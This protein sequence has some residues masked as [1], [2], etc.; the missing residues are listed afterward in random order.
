MTDEEIAEMMHLTI[1]ELLNLCHNRATAMIVLSL[2]FQ[3]GISKGQTQ[4]CQNY[5]RALHSQG[6]YDEVEASN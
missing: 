5:N 1:P 6:Y 3:R 4:I 2:A